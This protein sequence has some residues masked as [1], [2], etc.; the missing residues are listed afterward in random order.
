MAGKSEPAARIS[1]VPIPDD[2]TIAA[3][4]FAFILIL[5]AS[6]LRAFTGFGFA[7]LAVPGLMLLMPPVAAVPIAL[8]LQLSAAAAMVPSTRKEMDWRSLRLLLPGGLLLTPVGA[9]MLA[10]VDTTLLKLAICIIVMLIALALWRGFRLK[11]APGPIGSFLA[12]ASAGFLGGLAAI[13]GPPVILFYLSA[14]GNHAST[15]ASLNGFFLVLNILAVGTLA[16]KGA[17][18]LHAI[19]WAAALGPA[20]L[21][22]SWLGSAGFRRADPALFRTVAIGLLFVTGAAGIASSF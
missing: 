12:G 1:A 15:R 2:L 9:L 5:A 6:F 21:L 19:V 22:G 4:G 3:Y 14:P 10:I 8:L 17:F 7:L 16:L 18:D 11:R 20:M 13:P